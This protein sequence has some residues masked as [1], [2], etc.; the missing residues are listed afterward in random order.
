MTT[1][2][3]TTQQA[4]TGQSDAE[5]IDATVEALTSTL[6]F[7]LDTEQSAAALGR[8]GQAMARQPMAVLRRSLRLAEEHA[9]IATGTSQVAPDSRDRRFADEWWSS[10][11]LYKGVA[12]SYLVWADELHGLIDDLDLD[13]KSK[14]R[15]EFLANL[16]TDAAAPTNQLLGNPAAIKEAVRTGGRSLQDG[17][18]HYLHDLRDNGGMP[19]T[20]DTRPFVPGETI[21]ATPGAVVWSNPVIELIQYQ[22]TT[23]QVRERPLIIVPPQINKYY[24]LDLAPG[25]SLVEHA[26][27][28]G[29]QVFMV[30]W[31]NPGPEQRDWNLDTYVSAISEAMDAALEIT[32]SDDLNILGVCAG[33]MTTAALLGHLKAVGDMRV[34][35]ATFLVTVLDWEY[36]STMSTLMSRPV[37][38][39]STRRSQSVGVLPGEDLNRIFS[40]LRPND[41]V[42]NY[43]VNNYLMGKNPPAYDVLTWNADSTNLP[44]GLHADFT[45]IASTN[46]FTE[47][48][49]VDVLDTE[50][51]L[52]K[53]DYPAYVV[54]A[55]TDHITPWQAC[56]ETVNLLGG[57]TEF[58]LSSQ[59]HIQAL[60][61]PSGNPK[62]QYHTNP[63]TPQSPDE[64]LEGA[65]AHA[66]SWWDHWMQWLTPHGG[67]E[68]DAPAELGSDAHPA[69]VAAP[70]S[71][72]LD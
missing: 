5:L 50:I 58:V 40:W 30:S 18:R 62:G 8:V 68:I 4:G 27:A 36:P 51:D 70:G 33:G 12:Q 57:D 72:V 39:A 63:A 29:H 13:A 17:F 64:W 23:E 21:A 49:G 53:V 52:A 41:L 2:G 32:G 35:S 38:E 24:V 28:N 11:P 54:G 59:G 71:Y 37:V 46:A 43:W 26:V 6:P 3:S 16:V 9:R 56:Y 7:G 10:N 60:V 69:G 19:S 44:A 42:W 25:R 20:V 55:V 48:G 31:R 61:N 65:S 14:L 45:E 1:A 47:P 66:G 15:T 34:N 67:A 22:P